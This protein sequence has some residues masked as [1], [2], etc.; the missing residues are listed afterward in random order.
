MTPDDGCGWNPVSRLDAFHRTFRIT[1]NRKFHQQCLVSISIRKFS[2]GKYRI[3]NSKLKNRHNVWV[4]V[5]LKKQSP[6]I[7]IRAFYVFSNLRI[8]C[9]NLFLPR[10][11]L[12][13]NILIQKIFHNPAGQKQ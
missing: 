6:R 1:P 9:F 12:R 11:D 2:T 3:N 8:P 7:Q 4:V 10:V 5:E 13:I